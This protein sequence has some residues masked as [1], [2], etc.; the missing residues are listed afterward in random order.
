MLPVDG[1]VFCG[2]YV[3]FVDSPTI[4]VEIVTMRCSLIVRPVVQG[5]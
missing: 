5:W 4:C 3:P 2:G 1:T